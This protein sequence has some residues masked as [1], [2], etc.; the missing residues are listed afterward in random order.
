M[1]V[2]VIVKRISVFIFLQFSRVLITAIAGFIITIPLIAAFN[3]SSHITQNIIKY[4]DEKILKDLDIN[5]GINEKR[6]LTFIIDGNVF[7]R[8][9]LK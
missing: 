8:E 3:F 2:K 9:E 7:S 6:S 4:A 5:T 1:T